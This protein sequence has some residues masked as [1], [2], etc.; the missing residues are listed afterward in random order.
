MM[1]QEGITKS[2]WSAGF[3]GVLKDEVYHENEKMVGVGVVGV[4]FSGCL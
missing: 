1:G 4:F 3:H 2:V